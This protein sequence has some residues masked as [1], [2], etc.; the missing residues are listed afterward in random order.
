MIKEIP[1]HNYYHS[2]TPSQFHLASKGHLSAREPIPSI[3]WLLSG[4]KLPGVEEEMDDNCV[5]EFH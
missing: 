1:K 2:S 5:L 4:S 3:C